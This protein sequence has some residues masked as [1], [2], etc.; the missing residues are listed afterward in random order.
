MPDA[1]SAYVPSSWVFTVDHS[2]H[3]DE[4][5]PCLRC[6]L[7]RE[8]DYRGQVADLRERVDRA[9]ALCAAFDPTSGSGRARA[10]VS[11]LRHALSQSRESGESRG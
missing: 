3:E 4:A 1:S 10:F 5:I 6:A 8:G 11:D 9:L 7:E 2:D